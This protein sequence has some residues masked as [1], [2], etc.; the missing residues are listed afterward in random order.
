MS[1]AIKICT[2][3]L[4]AIAL[5][6]GLPAGGAGAS[7]DLALEAG[8]AWLRLIDAGE[9]A[10]AWA[11][12]G[13]YFQNA[14]KKRKWV[15]ALEAAR[16]PLGKAVSRKLSSQEQK[17]SIPGAPDGQYTVLIFNT[18]FERKRAGRELLTLA[19]GPDK[20]WRTVGYFIR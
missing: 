4:A 6:W 11:A 7:P 3:F 2:V 12:A 9:Y 14:I 13:P 15:H 5:L 1:G 16:K 20:R 19:L 10:G 17:N 8:T 18:S